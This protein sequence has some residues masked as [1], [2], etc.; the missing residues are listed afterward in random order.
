ME[1][2]IYEM[3]GGILSVRGAIV[4][5]LQAEVGTVEMKKK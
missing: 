5:L 2:V 3:S 4:T 1:P